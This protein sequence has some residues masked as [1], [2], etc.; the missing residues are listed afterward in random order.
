[1]HGKKITARAR[2]RRRRRHRPSPFLFL[3]LSFRLNKWTDVFGTVHS[4]RRAREP[5]ST[6]TRSTA[7]RCY[8]SA[9]LCGQK[10]WPFALGVASCEPS[11]GETRRGEDK[12]KRCRP[13]HCT[14][15]G[16]ERERPVPS[17]SFDDSCIILGQ[18][19]VER[20]L[21][22]QRSPRCEIHEYEF[23]DREIFFLRSSAIFEEFFFPL[24]SDRRDTRDGRNDGTEISRTNRVDRCFSWKII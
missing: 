24:E 15:Q 7:C 23:R 13:D 19:F 18:L 17:D 14:S 4:R 5:S 12:P 2:R 8:T 22:I 9:G 3:S 1:M 11:R 21:K 20:S 6:H 16:E 10:R